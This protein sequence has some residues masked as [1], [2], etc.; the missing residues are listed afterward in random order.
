MLKGHLCIDLH[1]H[2]SGFKE[3]YEQ[4]N[5][6]TNAVAYKLGLDLNQYRAHNTSWSMLPLSTRGLGGILLFDGLLTEDADNIHFP[7]DVHL[8]ASAGSGS[9]TN[10]ERGGSLNVA[11]SGPTDYGYVRVWDF[12]T[13]QANG[14]IKSVARTHETCGYASNLVQNH[15]DSSANS[16]QE[17]GRVIHYDETTRNVYYYKFSSSGGSGVNSTVT[18]D[19]YSRKIFSQLIHAYSPYLPPS[20]LVGSITLSG[21]AG[22]STSSNAARDF[23]APSVTGED[24]Y[25]YFIWVPGNSS[26]NGRVVIKRFKTSDASF[27]EDESWT[28]DLTIPNVTFRASSN[29]ES[30][31]RGV[32]SVAVSNSYLYIIAYDR[33]GVYRISLDNTD[34]I[35]YFSFGNDLWCNYIWPHYGSGLYARFGWNGINSSGNNENRYW[36]GLVYEDGIYRLNQMNYSTQSATNF[37]CD[38][39]GYETSKLMTFYSNYIALSS[40][41]RYLGTIANLAS[42]VTKTG[43]Q[44]MKVTYTLTDV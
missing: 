9:I 7:M 14:E 10:Y 26:G 8:V 41:N 5:L 13:S 24:G 3:R 29:K 25:L 40:T 18:Y 33:H 20:Q 38:T 19:I 39:A 1:N 27:E 31:E 37:L 6:I 28:K 21:I 32:S 43:A 17:S 11:E 15:N 12:T 35:R 22:G 30:T 42:P 44:S 4:D 2:N 34:N 23:W 36:T 16:F